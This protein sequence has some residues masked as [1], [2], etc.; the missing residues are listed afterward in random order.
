MKVISSGARRSR[1]GFLRWRKWSTPAGNQR[2][3][4]P[5]HGGSH[6]TWQTQPLFINEYF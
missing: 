1:A 5:I 6:S 4:P 3:L 2:S